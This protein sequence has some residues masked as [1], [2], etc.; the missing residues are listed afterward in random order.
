[1]VAAPVETGGAAQLG[2]HRSRGALL[3]AARGPT[4]K[5]EGNSPLR[6]F[7]TVHPCDQAAASLWAW[8]AV[9]AAWGWAFPG[10]HP[11]CLGG[12]LHEVKH[13]GAKETSVRRQLSR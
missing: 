1:M 11:R 4:Q 9:A 8:G 5:N 10:G 13:R 7:S 12:F 6:P 2:A 3:A